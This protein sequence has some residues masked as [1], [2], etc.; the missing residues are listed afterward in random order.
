M[1]TVIQMKGSKDNILR[2]R[3]DDPGNKSLDTDYRSTKASLR[4]RIRHLINLIIELR[5]HT[6]VRLRTKIDEID[7]SIFDIS[8]AI[9]GYEI[10][11]LAINEAG[12]VTPLDAADFGRCCYQK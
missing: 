4:N 6:P 2:V 3:S 8:N 12:A 1:E 9:E 11:K 5:E 10:D 7:D